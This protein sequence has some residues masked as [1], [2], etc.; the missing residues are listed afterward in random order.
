MINNN[1]NNL[2]VAHPQS[3]SSS[4]RFL[5]DLEFGNV[6]FWGEGKTGVPGKNL[7]EQRR[8]PTTN[9]T[10]IWRRRRDLNRGH[11]GGRR[12]LSPLRHPFPY[13]KIM[14]QEGLYQNKVNSSL[15]CT[16]NCKRTILIVE[17]NIWC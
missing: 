17:E 8:E 7:S 15:V 2:E 6:G 3:G 9:S 10:Y 16:R 11:I 5:I 12:A 14:K 1:N 4:A 13:V